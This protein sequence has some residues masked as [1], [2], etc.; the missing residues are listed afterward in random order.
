L[1]IVIRLAPNIYEVRAWPPDGFTVGSLE[2]ALVVQDFQAWIFV[3]DP[4]TRSL[5][6]FW[7]SQRDGLE[8]YKLVAKAIRHEG[9]L[10]RANSYYRKLV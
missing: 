7:G 6:Y 2:E 4:R 10:A 8:H 9:T 5:T 3:D 1:V